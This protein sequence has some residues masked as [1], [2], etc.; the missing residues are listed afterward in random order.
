M[1]R[2]FIF[3]PTLFKVKCVIN[4]INMYELCDNMNPVQEQNIANNLGGTWMIP[5][6]LVTRVFMC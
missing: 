1:V 3:L 6:R 2:V 4:I 5:P